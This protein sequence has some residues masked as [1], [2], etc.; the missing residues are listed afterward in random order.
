MKLALTKQSGF[1]LVEL[2]IVLVLLGIIS[3]VALPKFFDAGSI[4]EKGY[5]NEVVS[6]LR[7]GQK[8]AMAEGVRHPRP[9][10]CSGSRHF[11]P[12]A[13]DCIS[14]FNLA[15][16][17]PGKNGI[18]NEAPPAV[19]PWTNSTIVFDAMGRARNVAGATTDFTIIVGGDLTL[20]VVG[21]TG[22]IK[23]P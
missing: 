10:F 15:V 19:S 12:G 17:H 13:C 6:A 3:V 18:Y 11:P 23:S 21:E 4:R 20:Q 22:F 7:Y 2:V 14:V 1:T 5:C 8:L 9:N 16:T